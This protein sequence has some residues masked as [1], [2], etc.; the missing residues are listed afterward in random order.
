M[1][2]KYSSDIIEMGKIVK[3]NYILYCKKHNDYGNLPVEE[4]GLVGIL[5]RIL[6]K[7]HRAFRLSEDGKV[8][9]VVDENLEDTLRDLSNYANMGILELKRREQDGRKKR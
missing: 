4:S 3:G 2:G 8:G 6:D 1:K 9:E 5:V 7:V